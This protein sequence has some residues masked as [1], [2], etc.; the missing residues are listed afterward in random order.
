[1]VKS[2][3]NSTGFQY[4][5]GRENNKKNDGRRRGVGEYLSSTFFSALKNICLSSIR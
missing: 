1:M 2:L 3:F 5:S 4:V